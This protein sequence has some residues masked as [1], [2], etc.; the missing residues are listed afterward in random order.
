MHKTPYVYPIVG[1]RSVKH[2]ESNIDALS[3]SLTDEDIKAIDRAAPFDI[4]FP[5][6]FI[7]REYN[8]T[9]TASDVMLTKTTALIDVPPHP[10]PTRP[11][12]RDDVA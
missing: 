6:N 2:L 10:A 1:Q 11:H 9:M 3:V 5:M 4:G 7:F 8:S 12:A